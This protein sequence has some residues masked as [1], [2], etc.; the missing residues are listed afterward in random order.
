MQRTIVGAV[1]R[2][3]AV[4]GDSRCDLDGR[5]ATRIVVSAG[6]GDRSTYPGVEILVETQIVPGGLRAVG[7]RAD[8]LCTVVVRVLS[9]VA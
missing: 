6:I 3:V 8:R 5:R 7:L 9:N 4:I 2:I 1:E